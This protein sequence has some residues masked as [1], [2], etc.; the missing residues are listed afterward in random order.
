[1]MAIIAAA[2]CLGGAD[3]FAGGTYHSPPAPAKY[4]S[5]DGANQTN[6]YLPAGAPVHRTYSYYAPP[7]GYEVVVEGTPTAPRFVT[8]V[9]PDGQVRTMR[10]EGPV[11]MRIRQYVA[12]QGSR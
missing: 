1:M 11:V 8:I 5:D 6:Y 7:P 9:G 3:A 4:R 2:L 10:L 12:R